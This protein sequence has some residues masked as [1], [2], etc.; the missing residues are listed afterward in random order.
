ME[1]N[2]ND[3]IELT[4]QKQTQRFQNKTYVYQRGNV[5]G[6]DKLGN[7]DCVYIHIYTYS[8]TTICEIDE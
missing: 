7:W 5:A 6:R 1:S 3:S 4:K 2:K 8:H